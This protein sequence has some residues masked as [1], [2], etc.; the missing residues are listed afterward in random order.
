MRQE[1]EQI[2]NEQ[3]QKHNKMHTHTQHHKLDQMI[4]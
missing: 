2:E 4:V 3:Q 1:I